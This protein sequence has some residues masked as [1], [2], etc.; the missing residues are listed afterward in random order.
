MV[1][2]KLGGGDMVLPPRDSTR[3]AKTDVLT[4]QIYEL[5]PNHTN[6]FTGFSS[7]LPLL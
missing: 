4:L 2:F 6:F 5:S 7:L 1:T 3:I